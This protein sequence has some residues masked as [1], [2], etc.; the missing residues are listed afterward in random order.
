MPQT[1]LIFYKETN[2]KSP[3]HA[4][5]VALRKED[6]KAW[7]NCRARIAQLAS[8]G[9]ELRRPAADYLRDD[10]RELRAKLGNVQYRILYFFHG[11]NV[12][13][14]AHGMIKEGS[15][16]DD[17]DIERT[18]QRREAFKKNPEAHTF[19]GDDGNG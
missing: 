1:K 12:A 15:A 4:W 7:A 2:G 18:I 6:P 8:A 3:V 14:L 5:L 19:V 11:H 9:H 10:I 13:V 16:V 17:A